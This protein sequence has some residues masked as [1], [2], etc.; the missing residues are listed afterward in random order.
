MISESIING[1]ISGSGEALGIA[2]VTAIAGSYYIKNKPSDNLLE[3]NIQEKRNTVENSEL[4]K[5]LKEIDFT[6]KSDNHLIDTSDIDWK[7]VRQLNITIDDNTVESTVGAFINSVW[8]MLDDKSRLV[9]ILRAIINNVKLDISTNK[10]MPIVASE[11]TVD[12][13]LASSGNKKSIWAFKKSF[14]GCNIYFLNNYGYQNAPELI[15]I[16]SNLLSDLV[17][18]EVVPSY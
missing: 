4:L 5:M 14:Y 12:N 7:N 9:F 15:S 3:V 18:I 1:I 10:S 2:I 6:A 11:E 8:K 17:K 16:V 13:W